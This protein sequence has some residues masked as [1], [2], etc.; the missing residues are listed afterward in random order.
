MHWVIQDNLFFETGVEE[1]IALLQKAGISHSLH[2]VVPFVGDIEPDLNMTGEVI[3]MGA[4]SMRHIAKRKG[5][6]PGVFDLEFFDYEAQRAA[7]PGHMLNDDLVSC[8]FG[9][10][11]QKMPA[12]TVFIRP[13]A[14]S[15]FFA[16]GVMSREE[17]EPWIKMVW[18]ASK[19]DAYGDSLTPDTQVLMASIKEIQQEYRT[20]IVDGRVVTA[21]LYKRGTRVLYSSDVDDYIIDYANARAAEFSPL[22]AYV[23][24]VAVTSEGLRII[25]CNTFNAAGLY[26]GNVSKIVE[27]IEAMSFK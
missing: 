1:M 2:K 24:D 20:W 16:G 26:A 21:S 3:C 18:I 8:R 4:Y 5:W 6:T 19:D 9:E 27:A 11:P 17:L 22:R 7:W 10:V 25:E 13:L 14:D 23:M 12:E 15:K